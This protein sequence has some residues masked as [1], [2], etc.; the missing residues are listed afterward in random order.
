ML[1]L[2]WLIHNLCPHH[3]N[4]SFCKEIAS[5]TSLTLFL[6]WEQRLVCA[7]SFLKQLA[8]NAW[9]QKHG[10]FHFFL[11]KNTWGGL[12]QLCILTQS[13][14][15]K[16][17]QCPIPRLRQSKPAAFAT[18]STQ[19]DTFPLSCNSTWECNNHALHQPLRKF[20]KMKSSTH[21]FPFLLSLIFYISACL[22][23]LTA[24]CSKLFNSNWIFSW[25]Y[26]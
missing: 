15:M 19:D 2:S 21:H 5:T 11:K 18:V 17:R 6:M 26:Q 8:F 16:M 12:K 3:L 22:S 9:V 13:Y 7:F 25:E 4:H 1:S 10:S 24:R 14:Q 23:P 20:S